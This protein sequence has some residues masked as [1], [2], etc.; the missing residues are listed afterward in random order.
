[1]IVMPLWKKISDQEIKC[2]A[3]RHHC[4]IRNNQVGRCGVRQNVA[5]R[6]KLLVAGRPA[7]VAIDPIEKKPLFHFLPGTDVYSIG[8]IGCNFRC[9]FCQNWEISQVKNKSQWL[10]N[11]SF[12]LTTQKII[13][14]C[15]A[16]SIKSIAFTYNEPTIFSEWAK[17][18]MTAA[19]KHGLYGIFVSNG[20]LTK[21]TLDYLDNEI[22]AYNIDLKSFSADFYRRVCGADLKGVLTTIK[23]IWRRKKWLEI[24][25][26]II[27]GLNDGDD[28]LK[29]IAN[30]LV[31]ISPEIVWHVS[32]FFPRYRLLSA[33]V[34]TENQ[35]RRA[36]DIGHQ[37]GLKYV[38]QGNL[39]ETNV[40]YCP[41]CGQKVIVRHGYLTENYL[42]HGRCPHCHYLLSGIWE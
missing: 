30:F 7:A 12:Q 21:Q 37:A 18:I 36:I 11:H 22:D 32:A 2:L 24:T 19:K 10:A 31:N 26:L 39:N 13:N 6:L 34:T 42:E 41:E 27:P 1:M 33:P 23:E 15:V 20:Y 4:L 14:D 16:N 35:L 38:Y 40:T 28:E 8:T 25:T 3:C 17:K 9:Q 29:Q 5:G